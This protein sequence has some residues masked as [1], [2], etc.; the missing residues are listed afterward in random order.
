MYMYIM[1]RE[2]ENKKM[3]AKIGYTYHL[4]RRNRQLCT[5][6]ECPIHL[7]GIKEIN[8]E[9]DEQEFYK[10]IMKKDYHVLYKK[11]NKKINKEIGSLEKYLQ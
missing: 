1:D 2:F 8:A 11:K 3:V 9:S 5:D 7:I 6:F 4:V 10:Y